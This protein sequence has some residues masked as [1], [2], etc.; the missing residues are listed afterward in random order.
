ML[1]L[2]RVHCRLSG[3][4]Y[5]FSIVDIMDSLFIT[6]SRRHYSLDDRGGSLL[7]V[8]I[9]FL[10]LTWVTVSLRFYVRVG[11]S[12]AAGA[13]DFIMLAALVGIPPTG[14]HF[15]AYR[16]PVTFHDILRS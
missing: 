12:H 2:S 15:K 5:E 3:K 13:D 1:S 6:F 9:V 16:R 7:A 8:V 14:T 11:I 10:I 4:V